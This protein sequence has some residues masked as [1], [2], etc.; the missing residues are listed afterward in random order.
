[1]RNRIPRNRPLRPTGANKP[2]SR[3]RFV[4]FA[5]VREQ[6]FFALLGQAGALVRLRHG[7]RDPVQVTGY[8]VALPMT[9]PYIPADRPPRRHRPRRTRRCLGRRRH[10]ASCG[11]QVGDFHRGTL[12]AVRRK[13]GKPNCACAQPGRRGLLE[14]LLT[15]AAGYRGPRA[16]CAAGHHAGFAGYQDKTM[17]TVLGPVTLNRTWYHC[18]ACAHDFGPKTPS[19]A[20]PPRQCRRDWPR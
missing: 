18:E 20:W 12:N 16:E 5:V 3:C 1:M 9:T 8:A 6:E 2:T 17:D 10:P 13:C 19:S 14:D 15:A 7:T 11:S 4:S